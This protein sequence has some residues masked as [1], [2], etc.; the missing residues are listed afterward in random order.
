MKQLILKPA[1][2]FMAMLL[3]TVAAYSQQ[4]NSLVPEKKKDAAYIEQRQEQI[5]SGAKPAPTQ[6]VAGTSKLGATPY[7][8]DSKP[9]EATTSPNYYNARSIIYTDAR[10]PHYPLT[11]DKA[12]DIAN[13]NKAKQV[14]MQNNPQA[15]AK[16]EM[17][18][19]QKKER[20]ENAK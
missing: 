5:N 14:W 8:D 3:G 13:Y 10:T 19:A 11:G 1:V 2:F 17:T 9:A 12:T 18:E 7:K 15:A 6:K 20:S 16:V 4:V